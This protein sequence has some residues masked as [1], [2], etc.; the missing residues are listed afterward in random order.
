MT[1]LSPQ[2]NELPER[3]KSA[4]AFKQLS[5]KE[6]PLYVTSSRLYGAKP[7]GQ[8]ELPGSWHGIKGQFTES[9]AG[10]AA[11]KTGSSDI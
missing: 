9:L 1:T 6:H 2:T 10:K 7:P 4:D 5:K 3:F 11:V 8:T